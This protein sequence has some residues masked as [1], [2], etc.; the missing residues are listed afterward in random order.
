MPY[1][2]FRFPKHFQLDDYIQAGWDEVD[3]KL[4]LDAIQQ[5]FE[6]S[7]SVMDLR[8]PY[9]L[10]SSEEKL[11]SSVHMSTTSTSFIVV[12]RMQQVTKKKWMSWR[13]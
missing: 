4:Y 7:N 11:D 13:Q 9:A 5:S 1:N 8:V 3:A 10:E 6:L 12:L 2:P